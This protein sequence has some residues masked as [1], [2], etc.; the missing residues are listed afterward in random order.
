MNTTKPQTPKDIASLIR[1]WIGGIRL[2]IALGILIVTGEV[3][4]WAHAAYAGNVTYIRLQEAYAWISLGLLV[5]ALL[6]GPVCKLVPQ[7]PGKK[8][9]FEA[10][11]LLGIGAAWFASLHVLVTYGSQFNFANP[12]SLPGL[13]PGNFKLAFLLG[14]SALLILLAMAFTSFDRAIASLG[15]WW[16]R[17]HRL[18][19]AA[20]L[21][22]MFHA[23]MVGVH[24]TSLIP[25]AIVVVMALV[26][27]TLHVCVALRRP[28]PQSRWQI[29]TL[30]VAVVLLLA[31]ANYGVQQ[32]V[33]KSSGV[34]GGIQGMEMHH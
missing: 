14:I 32:Y 26:L 31:I 7:I 28:G 30:G 22:V 13:L 19:Y 33:T 12:L 11:R 21:L 9:F 1:H 27:V 10:R 24:A 16:F 15:K 17:L 4:W 34:L 3:W 23:F 29:A 6:I 25:L 2:Y 18:I 5:F 20:A 8:L